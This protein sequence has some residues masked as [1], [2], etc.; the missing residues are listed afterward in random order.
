MLSSGTSQ[1]IENMNPVESIAETGMLRRP[2]AKLEAA[3][4]DIPPAPVPDIGVKEALG[5]LAKGRLKA[6]L[7]AEEQSRLN[8]IRMSFHVSLAKLGD[9]STKEVGMQELQRIISENATQSA[10]RI[11][12]GLITEG[13]KHINTTGKE[14]YVLLIGYIAK[15]YRENLLDPIDRPPS[16]LKSIA[17]LCEIVQKY[18]SVL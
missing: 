12:V 17:R 2:I 3:K 4:S 5:R 13:Q 16:R 10:L 6:Q 18:L 9:N 7:C 11:F 1:D 8:E 15:A 14:L